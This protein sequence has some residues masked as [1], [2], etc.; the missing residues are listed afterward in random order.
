[1]CSYTLLLVSDGASSY[2]AVCVADTDA[3]YGVGGHSFV[4]VAQGGHEAIH[5]ELGA[6][7]P[8]VDTAS[9]SFDAT[10]VLSP[11]FLRP[12]TPLAVVQFALTLPK[13]PA[14]SA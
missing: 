11:S 13:S 8:T 1:M 4:R 9:V 2:Q 3:Q 7:I 5:A 14:E 6:S 10:F 12:R